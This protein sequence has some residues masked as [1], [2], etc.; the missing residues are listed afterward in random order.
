MYSVPPTYSM[1]SMSPQPMS[2][3]QILDETFSLYRRNFSTFAAIAVFMALP[4]LVL[5]LMLTALT[6]SDLTTHIQDL[7]RELARGRIQDPSEL[8]PL[9]QPFLSLGAVSLIISA[10]D[11]F[12][13]RSLGE[14]ASAIGVRDAYAQ[15]ASAGT[16]LAEALRRI[17]PL[18]IWALLLS[19]IVLVPLLLLGLVVAAMII[20]EGS[21][22]R[23]LFCLLLPLWPIV[24]LYLGIKLI[25]GSRVIALEGAGISQAWSRSWQLTKGAF[26]RVVGVTL[27]ISIL[28]AVLSTIIGGVAGLVPALLIGDSLAGSIISSALSAI[29]GALIAPITYIGITLLY[30]DLR[31]QHDWAAQA[32]AEMYPGRL[33]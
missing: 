2:L 26:W 23:V 6:L 4:G 21:A 28:V 14:A 10:L 9:L 33:S 30:Y 5:S 20:N 22:F 25:F 19:L 24:F 7:E 27:A 32:P 11:F 17:V 16:A 29:V 18:V 12:V 15:Q 8:L 13:F 3:S 1:P 31:R